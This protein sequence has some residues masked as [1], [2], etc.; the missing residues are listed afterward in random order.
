MKRHPD[1][2]PA[3]CA[4]FCSLRYKLI[5]HFL[6]YIKYIILKTLLNELRSWAAIWLSGS[7]ESFEGMLYLNRKKYCS[8][9]DK[10]QWQRYRGDIKHCNTRM[11]LWRHDTIIK[12]LLKCL[13]KRF[14]W[15]HLP[16]WLDYTEWR[17][18]AI[19]IPREPWERS[20]TALLSTYW[21]A[22]QNLVI[23]SSIWVPL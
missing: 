22:H 20:R 1:S 21:L 15:Q 11:L 10:D 13:L 19:Q 7:W 17:I 12:V 9:F 14:L 23:F 18:P 16:T 4:D 2:L 3:I 8:C 5:F 6:T